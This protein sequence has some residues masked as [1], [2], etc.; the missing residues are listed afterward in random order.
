M[1]SI[2][3]TMIF[4]CISYWA[5]QSALEQGS[6]WLEVKRLV[7][8]EILST[9][10][11]VEYESTVCQKTYA[12]CLWPLLQCLPPQIESYLYLGWWCSSS[13][14]PSARKNPLA[15]CVF[16]L[17]SCCFHGG[18][19]NCLVCSWS[20]AFKSLFPGFGITWQYEFCGEISQ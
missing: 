12:M 5:F 20:A 19:L 8:A 13:N 15:L 14:A 10:W 1:A 7:L 11:F 6:Q 16:L 17:L 4:P 3:M 2:R 9:V 18:V